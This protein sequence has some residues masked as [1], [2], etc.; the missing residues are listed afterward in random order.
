MEELL[1]TTAAALKKAALNDD[2]KHLVLNNPAL[3]QVLKKA[4][5]RYIGGETIEQTLV[6]AV[7]YNREGYKCSIE[8]MGEN[9]STEFEAGLATKEFIKAIRHIQEQRLNSTI[10]LDLSHIG[11]SLSEELCRAN[12]EAICQAAEEANIEV[13]ISAEDTY[14]TDKVLITYIDTAKIFKNLSIT[15]QVYL[16]RTK[17]DLHE[18]MKT[19]GRIRLVKGAFETP[20]E[21]AL[22]RGSKLNQRYLDFLDQ[23]LQ[24]EHLCSIAT[25]DPY[26]QNEAKALIKAHGSKKE[27]YEFESL[28]GIQ[29]ERLRRL[30]DEGHPAKLYFV[31]GTQWYLYLC[32]R[33]AE[34]P[35]NVF[36]ALLDIIGLDIRV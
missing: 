32:N 34:Y 21:L 18:I 9:I 1:N 28:H 27:Y 7:H 6:K 29:T 3:Y 26:V 25:H 4:A 15:L 31:Y 30:K 10:S 17:D 11:L 2:A 24:R 19:S 14:K 36:T 12:L 35:Q 22:P 16:H 20:P 23:L 13:T 8:F 5:D 33:L